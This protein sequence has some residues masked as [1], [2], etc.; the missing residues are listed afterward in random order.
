MTETSERLQREYVESRILSA[1]P[2]ETVAM[3]YQ[4]AIES[5][6]EAIRCLKSRDRMTRARMVTRAEKAIHELLIALNPS[7]DPEFV[8]NSADLYRYAL[9]RI[10][11]GH[12]Q[13][14]EGPFRE[15]LS[16]LRPLGSAWA[17]LKTR[18]HAEPGAVEVAAIPEPVP[19]EDRST[20]AAVYDPYAAYRYSGPPTPSRDWSL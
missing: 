20:P 17:E 8:R 10:I 16:V 15:A 7:V 2:V 11:A 9:R 4:I 18:I 1:H 6:E 3:L 14:T 12:A 19:A 13:Q 5:L